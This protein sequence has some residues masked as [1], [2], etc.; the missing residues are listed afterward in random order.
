MKFA[1]SIPRVRANGRRIKGLVVWWLPHSTGDK[2]LR[3]VSGRRDVIEKDYKCP[4]NL[5]L[6]MSQIKE[7]TNI[8]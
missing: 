3:V 4:K 8:I 2:V 7:E 6:Q 5:E 1:S